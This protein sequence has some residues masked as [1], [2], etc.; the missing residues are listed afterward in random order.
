MGRQL[1]SPPEAAHEISVRQAIAPKRTLEILERAIYR[2]P[3][4]FSHTPMIRIQADLGD[5][6]H[7]PTCRL[8]GFVDGL[9]AG[10]PGLA[11]HGCGN[12]DNGGFRRR[13]EDGTWLGHVVEH[14]ALELQVQVGHAVVRGKT[15]GVRGREGVYNILFAYEDEVVGLQAGLVALQYVESLLPPHLRGFTGLKRLGA[16]PLPTP[17]DFTAAQS[18]LA[19]LAERRRLGPT[20]RSIVEAARRRGIPVERLDEHSLLRLGWGARQKLVRASITGATGHIAVETASDKAL[21]KTLL[22]DAGLPAPRGEVVRSADDAVAAARRLGLPVVTKPLD[23]NHG[24]GVSVG[25]ATEEAV[26]WGFE[27]ARAHGRRVVVEQMMR[28]RDFRCL[29]I[30]GRLVAVAERVPAQVTGDGASTIEAL[31][32]DLNADPRRG[33]GHEKVM[34]KVRVDDQMHELLARQGLTLTSV[35]RAGQVVV[36]RATANLSTGGS[37]IDCTDQIHADVAAAVEQAAQVVGLDVAGIDLVASDITRALDDA[38]GIV[39][40]NAAPGFRM[41]LEPSEGRPRDVAGPLVDSLI[42]RRSGGRIP[43]YAI[44]GTNGK[45]TTG[46]MVAAILQ[47]SGARVGLTNTS[48]VYVEGRRIY[49]GDAS[50]PRSARRVLAHP[51]VDAAVLEVARGG[52]L[53]EGL[54]FDWADA[55]AVLNVTED[56]IGLKGVDS[57]QDLANV[58]AVVI[59]S[60]ARLGCSVLN[61]DDP[62]TLRMARHARGRLGWFSLR[63]GPDLPLFLARHIAE[64]GMA[65]VY[66]PDARQLVL[67]EGGAAIP[68][69][70]AD[71]LPSALGGDAAFNVANALAAALMTR[72]QG[73]PLAAIVAGLRSFRSSHEDNPGRLNIHDDHGFRVVI[74]Y[75]HNPAALAA[76]GQLVQA[77][78]PRYG[79]VIGMVSIPGDRRDEDIRRMGE[80]AGGLFDDIVFRETPDGRGRAPGEINGLMTEGAIDAGVSP[81]RIRRIVDE[82]EATRACLEMARAGDLVV[83]LPTSVEDVWTTL[84]AFRPRG[85]GPDAREEAAQPH[86]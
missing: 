58:K 64:G 54:G 37:A 62:M 51:L 66:D 61:A 72:S 52:I 3:H 39:E 16:Q 20:T 82:F 59:E 9:L 19:R 74:D 85:A 65:A 56:H 40:V 70:Q 77:W 8:P 31:L 23:G 26:R 79:R 76:L 42:P 15:R 17:F 18:E 27:Q 60:V 29:V 13:L 5:L 1:Q 34:T 55:G 6:E 22:L 33:E 11:E 84:T 14:V 57:L 46:R 83:L 78:R 75:A 25:L 68:L 73:V 71:D 67:H 50:G 30:G 36:L 63:G 21:T 7:W 32:A 49:A 53:R 2:G 81:H 35:P 12:R 47:A 10:L 38:S 45:S 28:G 24:R 41:H 4:Y 43:I 44:T 80:L 48:G 69:A 86:A